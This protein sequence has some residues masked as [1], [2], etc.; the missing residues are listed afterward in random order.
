MRIVFFLNP[1]LFNDPA[2]GDPL[3]CVTVPELENWNG[4]PGRD[5]K[6]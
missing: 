5:K 3:E 6:V 4:G 2:D 1:R